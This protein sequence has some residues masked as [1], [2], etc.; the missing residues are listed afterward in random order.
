VD[1]PSRIL[2]AEDSALLRRMLGDQLRARGY[3]V[4][5]VADGE[6]ALHAAREALPDVLLLDRE[7]PRLDG[8]AV[9][10]ALRA[11]AR[12]E[13]LPVIFVTSHTDPHELALGLQRGAHDYVRKP[14]DPVELE[15]RISTALRMSALREELARRNVELEQLART[16]V[17]TGLANRRHAVSTLEAHVSAAARHHRQLSV[18][19]LDIDRFK[20]VNDRL[21]HAAGD[22]VLCHVAAVLRRGLR[23][24]DLAAR[25]GGEEFLLVLPDV[26]GDSAAIAAERLREALGA[27]PLAVDGDSVIVTA[28]F[29]WA[30]WVPGE[31]PESV[32]ARADRAL[33]AAKHAGRDRVVA[34]QPA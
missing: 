31:T 32:I 29:G 8:L 9:L 34:A 21:G 16:D 33:Y 5:E 10:D 27:E 22:D 1:R 7:M 17:L 12:T 19:L 15:A 11:D 25:W 20:A 23:T 28:S 13:E 30:E 18:V 14:V 3:E 4:L 2:V 6:A 24:E 26:P